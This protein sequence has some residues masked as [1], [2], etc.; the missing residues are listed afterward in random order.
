MHTI[1]LKI[2]I[3]T[4]NAMQTKFIEYVIHNQSDRKNRFSGDFS[5]SGIISFHLHERPQ[6]PITPLVNCCMTCF[7]SLN[8]MQEADGSHI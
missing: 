5:A 6:I 8:R 2:K 4:I 3:G 7:F 1:I